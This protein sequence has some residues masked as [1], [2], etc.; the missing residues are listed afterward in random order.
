MRGFR[1]FRGS[2]CVSGG[3]AGAWCGL[4]AVG[5]ARRFWM[6]RAPRPIH[7]PCPRA[8]VPERASSWFVHE[9]RWKPLLRL[10]VKKAN[11]RSAKWRRPEVPI[12]TRPLSRPHGSCVQSA[13]AESRTV[14]TPGRLGR[15]GSSFALVSRLVVGRLCVCTS[16]VLT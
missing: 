13:N 1:G 6:L 4:S 14:P 3:R 12:S 8:P 2:G 16:S 7:C 5:R 15:A 10:L 9:V 11:E